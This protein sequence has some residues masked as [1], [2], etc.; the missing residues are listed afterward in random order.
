[1]H[2]QSAHADDEVRRDPGSG[3]LLGG[4]AAAAVL[5]DRFRATDGIEYVDHLRSAVTHF[6]SRRLP[7]RSESR[8]ESASRETAC[9]QR[10][11]AGFRP[12]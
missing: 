7:A 1:M 3:I 10:S 12:C 6:A 11:L 8:C 5:D 2:A 4:L 9:P